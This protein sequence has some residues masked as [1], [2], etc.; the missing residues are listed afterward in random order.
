MI[1]KKSLVLIGVKKESEKAV[2]NIEKEGDLHKGR[3][4]LYNFS[5]E[6]K[7]ILSVGLFDGNNVVKAGLSKISNSLFEFK[8][9][10]SK[11]SDDFSCA[12]VNIT[13][14][15]MTPILYGNT[16]NDEAVESKLSSIMSDE[17][18]SPRTFSQ[19][20]SI[21]DNNGVSYSADYENEINEEINKG[22][23]DDCIN[24]KYRKSF[25][26]DNKASVKNEAEINFYDE[27]RPRIE[28][29]FKDNQ[30][31]EYLERLIPNSK[32]VKVEYEEDGDYYILGLIYEDDELSFIVYGVPGVFTKNPPKEIAGKPVWFPLDENRKES[33]GYWL[34]YQDAKS[35]ESVEAIVE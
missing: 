5:T 11:F 8:G 9:D 32:W 28:K 18:S 26:C 2:L 34:S 30:K 21:L 31:E 15:E 23:K 1:V 12:I 16:G 33:F 35:G 25:Y 13:N 22:M 20:K 27:I 19:T 7:G 14:G 4:R 24:C 29:I 3:V 6:P 10:L 17:F